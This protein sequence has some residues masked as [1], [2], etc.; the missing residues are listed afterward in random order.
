MNGIV[1]VLL[2]ENAI[3][4]KVLSK[5]RSSRKPHGKTRIDFNG[6]K[7]HKKAKNKLN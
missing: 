6:E 4:R 1:N 7:Y 3:L 2:A 5:F